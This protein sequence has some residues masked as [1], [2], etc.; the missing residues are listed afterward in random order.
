MSHSEPGSLLCVDHYRQAEST[1]GQ[2]ARSPVTLIKS[3]SAHVIQLLS[4]HSYN[5]QTYPTRSPAPTHSPSYL[6]SSLQVLVFK[7]CVCGSGVCAHI[8]MCIRELHAHV[9]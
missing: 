9:C 1:T 4:E 5:G 2:H 8:I 3:R 7:L 6:T